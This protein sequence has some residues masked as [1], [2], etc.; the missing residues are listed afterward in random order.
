[1]EKKYLSL[2]DITAY[3]MAFGLSNY[4]WEIVIKWD[5]LA[6]KNHRRAIC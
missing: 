3:R 1:M 2:N 5:Y 6:Q 4:I